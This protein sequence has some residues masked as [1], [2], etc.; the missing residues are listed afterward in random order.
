[1]SLRPVARTR[2]REATVRIGSSLLLLAVAI[3]FV[4]YELEYGLEPSA[5][6]K[7][8]GRLGQSGNISTLESFSIIPNHDGDHQHSEE[9]HEDHQHSEEEHEDH[10][11]S[12]VEHEDHQHSEVEHEDHQH[13]EEEHEDHQRDDHGHSHSAGTY[14]H[15]AAVTDSES[16]SGAARD[17]LGIGGSVVDAGV[18][19]VLCLAVVH[20][21]TVSLGGTFSSIYFNGT[22]QNASVLSTIPMEPSP[23]SYGI[24][25][26]LQGLWSLH[27]EHGRKRWSELF[28][29]A[30]I[31]A[32]QGFLVDHSLHA[33]L[34]ENGMKASSSQGLRGLFYDQNVLRKVGDKVRNMQLGNTL[35]MAQ[36]MRDSSLPSGLVHN[37]L[38]DIE[39]T[40]RE[41]FH[42]ALSRVDP[43]SEEPTGLHLDGLT[44]YSSSAPTAGVILTNSVQGVYESHGD[45][46]PATISDHLISVSKTMYTLASMWPPDIHLARVRGPWDSAPVGSSVLVADTSG[47]VLVISLTLNSTFGSGFVAPST[48]ILLSDFVHGVAD[49]APASLSFWACPSVLLYE[50]DNDVMGLGGRGGSSL[51]FSV[52]RVLLH[53][54][55]LQMD[56]TESMNG[57]DLTPAA[58]DP[59][60]RY[61]GALVGAPQNVMAIE[62]RA[63]HVHVASAQD[64]SCHP[65]GL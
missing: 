61:F 45:K 13:S 1:R 51:P 32:R 14:H 19:A 43:R 8:Y 57:T 4:L 48:G 3:A 41:S 24:P 17:V 46:A 42:K 56:L 52:A 37:L 35:E 11:H 31:L 40:D 63:E 26:V 5:P 62:V 10:Q 15:A 29:H 49:V 53:H 47:D 50:A 36:T 7:V 6:P 64:G 21:H 28:S 39:V 2:C 12:E 25:T 44:L 9:E 59:W 30:I 16:C 65:A 18:A 22:S 33:A 54:V 34:E 27:R 60:L 55:L 20:P 58:P 23:T 38:S